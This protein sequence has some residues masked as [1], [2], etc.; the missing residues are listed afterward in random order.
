MWRPVVLGL[1]TGLAWPLV[2]VPVVRG[3]C[4]TAA[5]RLRGGRGAAVP[6]LRGGRTAAGLLLLPHFKPVLRLIRKYL[7]QWYPSA[8]QLRTD[9]IPK[10]EH[11]P[12]LLLRI[13][14]LAP[15]TRLPLGLARVELRCHAA[16]VGPTYT[17]TFICFLP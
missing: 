12:P 3:G 4:T 13:F 8:Q 11:T 9:T 17:S 14:R 1:T 10:S 6:R 7:I 2:Q 15:I 16:P 5:R